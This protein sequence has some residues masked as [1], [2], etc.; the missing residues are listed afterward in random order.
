MMYVR[1]RSTCSG[2]FRDLPLCAR[3]VLS[4]SSTSDALLSS[5]PGEDARQ[6]D[7]GSEE[8][9]E[10]DGRPPE[11]AEGMAGGGEVSFQVRVTEHAYVRTSKYW[12]FSPDASASDQVLET[13]RALTL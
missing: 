6:P 12:D 13:F 10:G 7:E 9:A 8:A 4:S 3:V 1:H 11:K 5:T 2:D